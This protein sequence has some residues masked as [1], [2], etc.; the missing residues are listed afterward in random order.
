[1]RHVRWLSLVARL[2][3]PGVVQRPI[4]LGPCAALPWRIRPCSRPVGCSYVWCCWSGLNW[5]PPPYQETDRPCVPWS[6]WRLPLRQCCSSRSVH[7]FTGPVAPK[8]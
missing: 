1:L 4:A 2:G 8:T 3:A 6:C 5:R 7:G